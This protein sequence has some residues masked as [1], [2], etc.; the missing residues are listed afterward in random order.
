MLFRRSASSSAALPDREGGR[1]LFCNFDPGLVGREHP[2][3]PAVSFQ[4]SKSGTQLA[5]RACD[6]L[7]ISS[8]VGDQRPRLNNDEP[9]MTSRPAT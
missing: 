6:G 4:A 1:S 2:D 3:R 7:I 5:K 8:A 9:P